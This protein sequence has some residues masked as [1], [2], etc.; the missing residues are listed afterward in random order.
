MVHCTCTTGDVGV[1]VEAVHAAADGSVVLY[2]AVGVGSAVA[3]VATHSVD[4][5]FC[6]RTI[7]VHSAARR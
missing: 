6:R 5:S 4:A 3:R 1:A 7:L 2:Y